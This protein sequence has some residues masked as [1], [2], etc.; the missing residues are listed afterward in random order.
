MP[1]LYHRTY[2]LLEVE[3]NKCAQKDFVGQVGK[4]I[5]MRR[6][7]KLLCQPGENLTEEELS[8]TIKDQFPNFSDKVIK[9]AAKANQPPGIWSKIAW[10]PVALVGVVG[11]VWVANLPYPMIR[12]PVSRVAPII[13]LPSYISMDHNYRQAIAKVEQADQLLNKA[14]SSADIN[15]G[16]E[17]VTEAKK[18]LDA[19]RVLLLGYYPQRYST[20]FGGSR[21]FAYD[22][23]ERAR[24][25]I[26]RM[27]AK[28]SQENNAQTSLTEAE[29]TIQTA[30]Q[31]YQQTD[32]PTDKQQAIANWEAAIDKLEEIPST[33]LAGKMVP[34][35]LAASK[36]DLQTE[37]GMAKG[38]Q[39][40]YVI[41]EAAKIFALQAA[42]VDPNQPHPEQQWQLVMNLW[43]QAINQLQEIPMDNPSF[44]E[45]QTKLAEY[46]ANLTDAKTRLQAE[47]ESG[48]AFK[49]AK[50]LIADW[51]KYAVDNPQRG[52]LVSKIQSIINQLESVKPGTTNYEEAQDLLKFAR[53]K[54]NNL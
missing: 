36:Q 54:Q 33:T 44:L 16:T 24:K 29:Q 18:H 20:L 3:V 7:D 22:E 48:K 28:I 4:D 34:P 30:K 51:Q 8:H 38:S 42:Q 10:I 52:L 26:E 25:Q 50:N 6:L 45:A 53:N 40:S 37:V 15:L 23:F 39:R 12:K 13:L 41:L 49:Q 35:K 2:K 9:K 21:E 43:K 32:T 19:L 27:E 1:R 46:Q 31:Q 17:K 11:V 47:R 14:T 5:V